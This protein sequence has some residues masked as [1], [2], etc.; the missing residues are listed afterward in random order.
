MIPGI[1][2]AAMAME[3]AAKR[4]E[5]IAPNLAQ[6]NMPGY[7]RATLKQQTFESTLSEAQQADFAFDSLGTSSQGQ[8]IDFTPGAFERTNHP[9]DFAIQGDGFFAIET[10]NETL[11]TRNGAFHVNGEGRLVTADGHPVASVGGNLTLPPD[12]SPSQLQVT[13]DGAATVNGTSIGKIRVVRFSDPHQLVS[14]GV[15]LFRAPESVTPQD[16]DVLVHQGTREHSNV[17][18]V[19]ELVSMIAA[20]RAYEAAQKAMIAITS[21]IENHTNL[22]G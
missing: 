2:S 9:V 3:Q 13:K 22:R 6:L 12:S 18:P 20:S 17:Q 7:R 5:L 16:T 1:Y 19:F 15:T 21:A 8:S 11:Y 14:H 10:P 4:H